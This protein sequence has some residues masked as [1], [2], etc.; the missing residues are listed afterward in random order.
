MAGRIR[1]QLQN[2]QFALAAVFCQQYFSEIDKKPEENFKLSSGFSHFDFMP[3]SEP[4][5]LSCFLK[6]AI[7]DRSRMAVFTR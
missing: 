1:F 2:K 3:R 6:G 7:T 5:Q 4:P